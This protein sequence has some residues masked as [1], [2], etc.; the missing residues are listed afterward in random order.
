VS[1]LSK[2]CESLNISQPYGPSR[3]VTGIVLLFFNLPS[4]YLKSISLS[5]VTSVTVRLY[6][7][8]SSSDHKVKNVKRRVPVEDNQQITLSLILGT[9]NFA[10]KH[11]MADTV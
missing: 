6:V 7:H 3:H 8:N 5:E 2:K 11:K 10:I 9:E 4:L 1:Q